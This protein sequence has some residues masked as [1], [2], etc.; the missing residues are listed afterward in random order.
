MRSAQTAN[1]A[2]IKLRKIRRQTITLITLNKT[3]PPRHIKHCGGLDLSDLNIIRADILVAAVFHSEAA[4]DSA[5]LFEADALIEVAR[6]GVRPDD[7]VELDHS[8]ALFM[9]PADALEHQLFAD[10]LSSAF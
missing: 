10:V 6:V 2:A 3:R 9:R 4:G 5:E 1:H 8:E 7:G